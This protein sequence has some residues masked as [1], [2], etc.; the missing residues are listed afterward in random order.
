MTGSTS[1]ALQMRRDE[2]IVRAYRRLYGPVCGYIAKRI[3]NRPEAEDLAQDVFE[4]IL[5]PGILLSED[6]VDRYVYSIAHNLVIDWYRRHACCIR[7]QEYFFA[8]SPLSK[9][10]SDVKV[11]VGEIIRLEESVLSRTSEAA[12]KAYVMFVHHGSSVRDIAGRLDLS[13]R[14]VENHMFKTR[15]RVKGQKYLDDA[16]AMLASLYA[17]YR[18]G[19]INPSFLLHS[20]GHRPAGSEIDYSI[21]YADYYYIEALMRL[22][23]L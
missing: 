7:A 1:T 16:R 19:D 15:R 23:R 9:D 13:E 4:S 20:T 14:S 5:K 11:R 6:T 12:R 21:I 17:N 22:S 18:S 8:H 2:I 10:D 3:E